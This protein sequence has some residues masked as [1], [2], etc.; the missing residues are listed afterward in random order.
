MSIDSRAERY[1]QERYGRQFLRKIGSGSGGRT[2]VYLTLKQVGSV[3]DESALKVVSVIEHSGKRETCSKDELDR[4]D[5]QRGKLI[6]S[7]LAEVGIMNT[8]KDSP[9]IVQYQDFDAIDYTEEDCFGTDLVIRMELL[10]NLGETMKTKVFT[11]AEIIRIGMHLCRALNDCH[12]KKVIHRDIKPANIFFTSDNTFKLG[13]FGVSEVLRTSLTLNAPIGTFCYAAPEQVKASNYDYRIDIYSLGLVLYELANGNRLPFAKGHMAETEEINRRLHYREMLPPPKG[14]P[15]A[16]AAVIQKACAYRPEDR[17]QS[18][19]E[20]HEALR[21]VQQKPAAHQQDGGVQKTGG[22]ERKYREDSQK[23]RTGTG[24]RQTRTDQPGGGTRQ[25]RT[26][27][28]GGGT[29]QTRTDRTGGGTRQTRTDQTRGTRLYDTDGRKGGTQKKKKS[30]EKGASFI[31]TVALSILGAAIIISVI[32]IGLKQLAD[33]EKET[34]GED[35][36]IVSDGG[37]GEVTPVDPD[38]GQENGGDAGDVT[39][40]AETAA[41]STSTYEVYFEDVSWEEAYWSCRDKGGHL[42]R[43]ET[44]E[45][46]LKIVDWLY[47]LDLLGDG[48]KLLYL[49]AQRE[50]SA[51]DYYWVNNDGALSGTVINDAS[52]WAA[53]YWYAGEPS[54]MDGDTVEYCLDL[55]SVD[56]VWYLNDVPGDIV[57]YA[58]MYSGKVGYICEYE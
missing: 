58:A 51:Y 28:T 38:P 18:A 53:K 12:E 6:D 30:D 44:E 37:S 21:K 48:S 43:I 26:D 23:G 16:L 11:S 22:G 57:S 13:D 25:T 34:E 27:R 35:I 52:N 29:R 3:R 47:S 55:F 40:T 49:S 31:L 36:T 32:A 14:A 19:R 50:K 24:T 41:A 20:F 7:S 56:G 15:S 46:Y 5:R 54:F 1:T 39:R 9:H 4:Y 33:R 8:L 17:F 10:R 2:G 45:E 42:V